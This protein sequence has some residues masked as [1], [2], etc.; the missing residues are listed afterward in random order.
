MEYGFVTWLGHAGFMV[1][2]SG[3][4]AFIDPFRLHDFS[5]K[6]DVIFITHPHFDHLDLEAIAKIS[7]EGTRFIAPEEAAKKIGAKN[8]TVVRPGYRG[9]V[10]GLEFEAVAAYNIDREKLEFHRKGSGWVGYVINVGGKRIYHA[11]D[12]DLIEE[13]SE[14]D[15]DL[16]LIPCGGK[17]VMDLDEAIR[18]TKVIKAKNFAPMHYRALLGKEGSERLE[19]RFLR[20]VKGAILLEENGEPAYSF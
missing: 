9:S 6:A 12:T 5:Q 3:L 8:M 19:K 14:I 20:E 4:R 11:G 2:A 13:M 15:A 18:A 7:K 10:M 17:Y 1:E 16:A